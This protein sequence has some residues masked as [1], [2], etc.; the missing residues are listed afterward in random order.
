MNNRAILYEL[1]DNNGNSDNYRGRQRD[2]PERDHTADFIHAAA[3]GIS[4]SVSILTIIAKAI[5]DSK[6]R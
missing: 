3:I 6:R 4:A 5:A 2:E 1:D